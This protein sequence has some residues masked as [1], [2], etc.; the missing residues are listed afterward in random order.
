MTTEPLEEVPARECRHLLAMRGGTAGCT[1]PSGHPGTDHEDG[2]QRD[3]AGEPLRWSCAD[4]STPPL[5]RVSVC[6][7]FRGY[8]DESG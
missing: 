8:L 7:T 3:E 6:I 1:L 2:E 5:Y 4:P